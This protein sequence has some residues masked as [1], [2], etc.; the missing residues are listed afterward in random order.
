MAHKLLIEYQDMPNKFLTNNA[1]SFTLRI[2]NIGEREFPSGNINELTLE[3]PNGAAINYPCE[4]FSEIPTL[5]VEEFF[6]LPPQ[7]FRPFLEGMSWLNL[8]I[9]ANDDEEIEYYRLRIEK[10]RP[11]WNLALL[12]S[13]KEEEEKIALLRSILEQL[14]RLSSLLEENRVG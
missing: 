12:I 10:S 3:H 6:E 5:D 14:E 1:Y 13:K 2:T 4:D 7:K 8:S 9:I 11:A